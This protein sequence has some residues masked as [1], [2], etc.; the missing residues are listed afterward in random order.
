MLLCLSET[1]V[2]FINVIEYVIYEYVLF[3]VIDDEVLNIKYPI[4]KLYAF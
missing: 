3:F 4:L 2:K 1:L